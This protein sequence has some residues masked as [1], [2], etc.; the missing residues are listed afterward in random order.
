METKNSY[1]AIKKVLQKF[2]QC[3][4][5]DEVTILDVLHILKKCPIN[6]SINWKGLKLYIKSYTQSNQ[7]NAWISILSYIYLNG[8]VTPWRLMIKLFNNSKIQN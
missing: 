6:T 8:H 1:T 3:N 7:D 4:E 5:G 2:Y